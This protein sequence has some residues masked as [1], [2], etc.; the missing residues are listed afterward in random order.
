M[1]REIIEKEGR[2]WDDCKVLAFAFDGPASAGIGRPNPG[3]ESAQQAIK[4]R[5]R[6]PGRGGQNTVLGDTW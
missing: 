3:A 5:T 6:F 1:Y 2:K 4:N